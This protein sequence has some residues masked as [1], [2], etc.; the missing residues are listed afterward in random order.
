MIEPEVISALIQLS[1]SRTSRIPEVLDNGPPLHQRLLV[2]HE[3]WSALTESL[4]ED[5]LTALIQGLVLL[6]RK[7]EW[8]GGSVSP[9]IPLY[10]TY[11]T[12]F[13]A[14]AVQLANWILS[15][16]TN[17]YEPFGS[18]APSYVKSVEEWNI[19]ANAESHDSGF[20]R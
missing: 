3:P 4:R 12:R 20:A 5:D 15:H 7:S 17:E 9:V 1:R 16:R 19:C 13:P 18:L 2:G 8:S 14:T 11:Q 10:Q 6:S